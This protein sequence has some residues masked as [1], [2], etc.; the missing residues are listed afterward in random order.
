MQL[1]GTDIN[2]TTNPNGEED[3][4]A[5]NINTNIKLINLICL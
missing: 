3:Q 4:G 1:I 5:Q 2:F